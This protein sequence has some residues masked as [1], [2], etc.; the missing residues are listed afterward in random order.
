MG[1]L[2]QNQRGRCGGDPRQEFSA[3][4][5]ELYWLDSRG[6]DTAAAVAHDL[7]SGTTRILAE[8]PRADFTHLLLD[9]ITERPVAAARTFE[10]TRWEVL[11]PDYEEDF[12]YLTRQSSGDLTITS[13]S[14]DRR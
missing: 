7:E 8:D 3:D 2:H 11:D 9:P 12:N 13:M 1:P 10:R 4:G 14:Q 5:R 6:R